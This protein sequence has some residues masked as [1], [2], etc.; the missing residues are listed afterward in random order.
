MSDTGASFDAIGLR[1][2]PQQATGAGVSEVV[3]GT[4]IATGFLTPLG[5]ALI[6]GVMST[7]IR[8]VHAG[9][10]PWFTAGG[11]EYNVVLIATVFAITDLGP[12]HFSLDRALGVEHSGPVWATTAVGLG[13][14]APVVATPLLF[15]IAA[16]AGLPV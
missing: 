5:S 3:G 11:W 10:G 7:A 13:A 16:E 12:G 1:P 15:L 6:S 9:K 2:R 4:L 14:A 8:K